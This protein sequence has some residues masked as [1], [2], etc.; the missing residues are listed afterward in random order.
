MGYTESAQ[1]IADQ[2]VFEYIIWLY[3]NLGYGIDLAI[4]A[5]IHRITQH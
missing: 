5:Y 1:I 2:T 3:L 4:E